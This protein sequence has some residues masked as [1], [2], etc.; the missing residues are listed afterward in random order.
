MD[1]KK[2]MQ[3]MPE[4]GLAGAEI[5]V[6]NLSIAL[7]EDGFDICVVSLYDYHS[8]IT[9]RLESENIPVF[10][11]G[12]KQGFDIKIIYQLYK[13][14]KKEKPDVVHTHRYILPYV[15]PALVFSKVKTRIHTIHNIAEKEVGKL[16]RKINYFFYKYCK[17]I[18]VSI[19]PLVRRS[20]I[21]EYTFTEN[22]SPMIYNGIDLEKCIQKKTY[23]PENDIINILHIGRFSEQKN[24]MM[25]IESF[26]IVHNNRPNTSLKLIGSGELEKVIKDKVRE[27][28]LDDC[29]EFLGLKTDVFP[30]LNKA[31]IF[32]LP[33]LW[34][35]MPITLIEAMATGLPIVATNVG[36]VPDMIEDNNT[37]FLVET[38]KEQISETLLKLINDKEL[39]ERIGNATKVAS[40]R[41][42]AKE[43]KEKYAKLYGDF[44]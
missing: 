16:Q 32:I 6:E 12:K 28:N 9:D 4:F 26:K 40:K 15:I 1:K 23:I 22:Q 11:L 44:R 17:V 5:M 29:V 25:L 43:M 36:G 2:V 8:A 7:A 14:L 42:S 13:L 30:Y 39:R 20:V 10:Y 27:L 34:E 24:H 19:S 3:I 33:S 18:P 41:F 21:K 35:G 38:N 31:D 37:G